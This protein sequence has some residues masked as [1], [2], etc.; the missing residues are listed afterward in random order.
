VICSKVEPVV[1]TSSTIIIS[2]RKFTNSGVSLL[3]GEESG[4]KEFTDCAIAF[5]KIPFWDQDQA[6]VGVIGSKRMDY[7]VV[8]PALNEVRDALQT[9]MS[10]WR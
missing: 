6:Y 4:V 9:S 2:E 5:I 7:T 3:I 8:I 10:G 1:I